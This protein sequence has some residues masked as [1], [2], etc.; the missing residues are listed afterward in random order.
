MEYNSLLAQRHFPSTA[1]LSSSCGSEGFAAAMRR[2]GCEGI[3]GAAKCG[4]LTGGRHWWVFSCLS[5]FAVSQDTA[6][7]KIHGW[8]QEENGCAAPDSIFVAEGHS[9]SG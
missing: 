9:L 3:E 6:H 1:W 8:G 7:L 5:L 2:G 4:N